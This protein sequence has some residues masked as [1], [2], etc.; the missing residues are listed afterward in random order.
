MDGDMKDPSPLYTLSYEQPPRHKHKIRGCG[1]WW[2]EFQNGWKKTITK[3]VEARMGAGR[4]CTIAGRA[5]TASGG[6]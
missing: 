5:C 3:W 4:A 6:A 1:Q 2:D